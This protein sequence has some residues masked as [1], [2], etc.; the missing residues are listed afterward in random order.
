[1]PLNAPSASRPLSQT[2]YNFPE[3]TRDAGGLS[4]EHLMYL[5]MGATPWTLL[6]TPMVGALIGTSHTILV[7][8]ARNL[9]PD[10]V[11][12]ASGLVP[13]FTF[14]S[15]SLEALP[16]RC[17]ALTE[18]CGIAPRSLPD[19]NGRGGI[20]AE[21]LALQVGYHRSRS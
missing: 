9:V 1:M 14:A 5:R 18:G 19:I 11:G 7:V 8:T 16:G 3:R 2:P 15:G 6:L 21:A 12:A 20:L 4:I 10:R 17:R 13:G